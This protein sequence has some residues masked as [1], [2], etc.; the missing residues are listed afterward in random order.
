MP[1]GGPTWARIGHDQA[2]RA[3]LT[4]SARRPS[5]ALSHR[6][7]NASLQAC[8]ESS[9][10]QADSLRPPS[11]LAIP[12]CRGSRVSC[13]LGSLVTFD[14]AITPTMTSMAPRPFEPPR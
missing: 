5:P 3:N 14:K 7:P 1:R 4:A 13:D 9:R 10:S 11:G 12:A 6:C 2:L 8:Q